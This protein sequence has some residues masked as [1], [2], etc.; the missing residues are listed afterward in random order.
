MTTRMFSH[1]SSTRVAVTPALPANEHVD[2]WDFFP[3]KIL[4][5]LLWCTN[6]DN[7]K[8]IVSEIWN[9]PWYFSRSFESDASQ[10]HTIH[11]NKKR[12]QSHGRLDR[13]F[14]ADGQTA[15]FI[16][17]LSVGYSIVQGPNWTLI[18][19]IESK[20]WLWW[21]NK[22]SITCQLAS[23]FIRNCKMQMQY[24]DPRIKSTASSWMH[25]LSWH[26]IFLTLNQQN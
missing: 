25:V 18:L 14:S 7:G 13:C 19:L 5:T 21:V 17:R 3:C 6:R 23:K 10:H 4:H 20:N 26:A 9:E 1:L 24:S 12:T 2:T 16:W 8:W 11:E 22:T 15:S